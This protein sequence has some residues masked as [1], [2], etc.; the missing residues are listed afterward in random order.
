MEKHQ[1]F[2]ILIVDDDRYIRENL[3]DILS[4]KG[5]VCLEAKNGKEALEKLASEKF[6]LLLLDLKIPKIDGMEVLKECIEKYKGLPVVMISGQGTIKFAVEATKLGAYDFLEKPL[7][8]E[9]ILITVNNALK[10]HSLQKQRDYLLAE[11]RYRYRLI[12]ESPEMKNLFEQIEKAT[13]VDSKVLI[14][15]ESGSGKE[16]VARTIHYKSHRSAFPFVPVNCSAVPETLIESELFGYKKGSFTGAYSE[17]QGKFEQANHGTLF[18][19]EIGDMSLMMQSKILR[20]LEDGF[21]SQIG[22]KSLKSTDTRIITATN[23]NL[24]SEVEKGNFRKDLFFRLN[25]IVLKI[26]PL[27]D[28]KSD[29][30]ILANYFLKE[31]CDRCNLVYKTFS[32][33]VFPVLYEYD[34]PGNVR[35][36]HNVIERTVVMSN[37]AKIDARMIIDSL[38]VTTDTS[39]LS[40]REKT[41]R[42][43]RANFEK[44]YITKILDLHNGKIKET[45]SALGIERT[46]LWKKMKQYSISYTA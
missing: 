42:E 14:L 45:A 21:I 5:F 12:G 8:A 36:L 19:D 25:V 32:D 11:T 41:L 10:S 13:N 22:N 17:Y 38:K 29:I 18:L 1:N 35:E 30:K 9:R 15:G 33:D 39:K 46:H 6:D 34:W 37:D 27:R 40:S 44:D 43:A 23:K 24:K 28:R 26:P 31:V 3:T 16:M 20:V 2:R 7:E 4:S